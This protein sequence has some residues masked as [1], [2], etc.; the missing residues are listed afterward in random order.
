M[1][2]KQLRHRQLPARRRGET[3]DAQIFD[4]QKSIETTL[5]Q[6]TRVEPTRVRAWWREYARRHGLPRQA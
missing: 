5:K 2:G 3:K 1:V 6:I 4:A